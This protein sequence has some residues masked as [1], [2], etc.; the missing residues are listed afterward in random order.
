VLQKNSSLCNQIDDILQESE[1]NLIDEEESLLNF[2][3]S[4]YFTDVVEYISGFVVRKVQ[5]LLD[6]KICPSVLTNNDSS[7]ALINIK[8]KGGLLNR[9]QML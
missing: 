6:C 2:A 3:F 9:H 8:N 7:S 1:I 4:S 5:K